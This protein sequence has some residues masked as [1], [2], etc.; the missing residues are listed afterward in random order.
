M[1]KTQYQA[2]RVV[3]YGSVSELTASCGS[4]LADS[5]GGAPGTA[6]KPLS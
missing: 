1:K 2:P 5:P 6:C 4:P 3:A